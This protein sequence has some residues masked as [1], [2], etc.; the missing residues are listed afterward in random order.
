[1]SIYLP[2]ASENRYGATISWLNVA[3]SLTKPC[4]ALE[5]AL[6]ALAANRVSAGN[7]DVRLAQAS[8]HYY[9]K[10]LCKLNELLASPESV[11]NNQALAAVRCLMIYEVR[12][13]TSHLS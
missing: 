8:R 2:S 6:Y 10:A 1:M 7:G 5:A 3:C 13:T 4:P 9:G 11:S 12:I